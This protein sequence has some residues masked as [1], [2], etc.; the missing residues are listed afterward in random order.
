MKIEQISKTSYRIRKRINGKLHSITFDHKPTQREVAVAVSDLLNDEPGKKGTFEFYALKYIENRSNVLS[1]ASVRTYN[2]KLKQ[3][4]K[5]FKKSDLYDISNESVQI[6]INKISSTLEPKTVK[7]TYGFIVSVLAAY[8]PNLR[9]RV[10]LPQKID[11][12]LYEPTSEDI[13]RI[14]D[15]SVDTEYH[16]P[17]MLGVFGCRR[18]EICALTLD[19]LDGNELRIHR[20]MVC[21]KDNNWVIKETPKTDASNRVIILPDDFV[22]EIVEKGYIYKN[23]PNALNKAIHRYQ[24]SLGI[25]QFKFHSLRSYFASYAHSIG[26]PESDILSLGGWSSPSIMKSVYRKSMIESKK[27]SMELFSAKITG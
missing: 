18:G 16:I 8:R 23:H 7:T 10:T 2:I 11:K 24:K 13:K 15:M 20:C 17:F 14:L 5:E 22:N 12:A 4:S 27:K 3:L 25:P 1:P 21:D 26:I 9:L 6:E 19:D